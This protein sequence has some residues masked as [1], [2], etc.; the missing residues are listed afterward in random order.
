M[1]RD[2][3]YGYEAAASDFMAA[4]SN[5]GTGIVCHW[6]ADLP[7]GGRVI[8]IGAGHG[9]PLTEI[10]VGAELDV[11]AIDASPT[12]ISE[13]RQNLPGV[14]TACEAAEISRFFDRQ[15]DGALAV[16]LIFLLPE[17]TQRRL[18]PRIA[19][20]LKPGGRLLFSAPQVQC[21]WNDVLTGLRSVS[22]GAA[23]YRRLLGEAGLTPLNSHL[24]EGGSHY[25]EAQKAN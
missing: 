24:D 19:A 18:V 22:L 4:R 9:L 25:F 5:T 15:F 1:K 17:E 8:D 13:L 16:G 23:E 20:T 7:Q 12:L 21:T 2:P 3:S 14:T 10:L 11:F 6:A